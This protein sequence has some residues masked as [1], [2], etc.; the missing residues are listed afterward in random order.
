MGTFRKQS[1]K[2]PVALIIL[3]GFTTIFSFKQHHSAASSFDLQTKTPTADA[4]KA[5]AAFMEAS[6]VF[7]S[8]RCTNC[9]TAGDVPTQGDSAKPHEESIS[10]G[11]EGKGLADGVSCDSCH[12]EQNAEGDG[13]PP[14]VPNWRM[15][16]E[17]MKMVFQGRTPAQ[18]CRQLKDPKQNG[19]KAKLV[20]AMHHMEADPLVIWAWSPGGKRAL[21]PLSHKDFM[22]RIKTWVDNG[23]ACP[24]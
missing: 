13:E 5:K 7:F 24:D 1:L 22:A 20:D 12:L 2:L 10:R 21:P 23:G 15:P 19:G 18:L 3:A 4:V 16:S 11:K 14:G 8:P 6:K 9:H 17:D